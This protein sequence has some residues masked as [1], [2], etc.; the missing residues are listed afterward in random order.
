MSLKSLREKRACGPQNFQHL[1]QNDFCNSIG[2]I[3]D[4]AGLAAGSQLID[5]QRTLRVNLIAICAENAIVRTEL[6]SSSMVCERRVSGIE[7]IV[8]LTPS[9]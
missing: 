9:C 7:V 5:P 1:R 4:M 6:W 2:G 3:A 8:A